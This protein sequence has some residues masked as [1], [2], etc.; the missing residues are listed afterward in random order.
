MGFYFKVN[1][2]FVG[3]V[4]A[5]NPAIITTTNFTVPEY[6]RD[7]IVFNPDNLNILTVPIA[8]KPEFYA[9]PCLDLI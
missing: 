3:L 9:M 7:W 8:G 6:N 1:S 2:V 5:L 4:R